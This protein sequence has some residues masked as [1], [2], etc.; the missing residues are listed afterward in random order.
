MYELRN[1]D[2][3][4]LNHTVGAPDILYGAHIALVEFGVGGAVAMWPAATRS[5]K[6]Y[7]LMAVMG[8]GRIIDSTMR[9]VDIS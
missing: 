7:I 8:D 4:S 6:E 9:L 1:E 3:S 2:G 5:N